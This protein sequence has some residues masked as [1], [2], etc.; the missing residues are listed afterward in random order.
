MYEYGIHGLNKGFSVYVLRQSFLRLCILVVRWENSS[1]YFV[2]FLIDVGYCYKNSTGITIPRSKY[3]E[4]IKISGASKGSL[5]GFQIAFVNFPK[6]FNKMGG[7]FHCYPS[8][9][10][11]SCGSQWIQ[12]MGMY[13]KWMGNGWSHTWRAW[14]RKE[15]NSWYLFI[16]PSYYFLI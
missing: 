2:D 12:R 8:L 16:L 10:S 5:L 11:W 6:S 13:L 15:R 3:C 9:A 14:G 1:L 4:E 7:L